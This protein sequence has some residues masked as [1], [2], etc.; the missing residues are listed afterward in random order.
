MTGGLCDVPGDSHDG[1]P[2]LYPCGWRCTAH[3]PQA[4]PTTAPTTVISPAVAAAA[5]RQTRSGTRQVTAALRIDAGEGFAIKDAP[6]SEFSWKT[7]PRA[8]YECVAC[9]WRSEVVTGAEAV[10][11]FLD[12][13]RATHKAACPASNTEGAQAA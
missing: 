3:A 10:R 6:P 4:R 7:P 11:R 12:H 5:Q 9:N 8:R 13:I 1:S 2:R